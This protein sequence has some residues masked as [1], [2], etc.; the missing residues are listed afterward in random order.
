MLFTTL[1][2][3]SKLKQHQGTF[4]CLTSNSSSVLSSLALKTIPCAYPPTLSAWQPS[5]NNTTFLPCL[6][7][8]RWATPAT[9]GWQR[10]EHKN[11]KWVNQWYFLYSNTK[12]MNPLI[13]LLAVICVWPCHKKDKMYAARIHVNARWHDL[14]GH[15]YSCDNAIPGECIGKLF[16]VMLLVH[17]LLSSGPDELVINTCTHC[18]YRSTTAYTS[19]N[20]KWGKIP[21]W[22]WCLIPMMDKGE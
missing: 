3:F 14:T 16:S 6:L 13:H 21:W 12:Q 20:R 17:R 5:P 18:P 9:R 15:M 10:E 22:Q 2:S 11:E 4:P 19:K 8:R 1:T 7:C